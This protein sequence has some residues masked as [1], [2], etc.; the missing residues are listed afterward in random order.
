M[1]ST[2][3]SMRSDEV[4]R[5]FDETDVRRSLLNETDVRRSL[6]KLRSDI[7]VICVLFTI[8]YGRAGQLQ[9]NRTN[10]LMEAGSWTDGGR[11]VADGGRVVLDGGRVF[12]PGT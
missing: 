8:A 2:M 12:R 6:L 1:L 5:L 7:T 10:S 9:G 11:V 3:A 4:R